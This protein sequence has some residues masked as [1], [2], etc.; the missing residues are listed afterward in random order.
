[1]SPGG[2]QLFFSFFSC[3]SKDSPLYQF[4]LFTFLLSPFFFLL[5]I[6][7]FL[8]QHAAEHALTPG[9]LVSYTIFLS[10]GNGVLEGLGISALIARSYGFDWPC[11]TQK[12]GDVE[13]PRFERVYNR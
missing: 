9:F 6:F 7:F 12:M 10:L 11:F 3:S 4:P 2:G 13:K 5:S 1:M 8:L